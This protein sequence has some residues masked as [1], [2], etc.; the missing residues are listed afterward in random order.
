[1]MKL[2]TPRPSVA[3]RNLGSRIARSLCIVAV[4]IT[5]PLPGEERLRSG[6]EPD[7]PPFSFVN[8]QGE[9]D[10]FSVALLQAT[11]KEMGRKAD[12]KV[13]EWSVLKQAL[14][15]GGL[16][17]LPLVGRTPEREAVYDFTI[18]YL[19]LRGA[20]FVQRDQTDISGWSDLADKRVGVMKGD[21]SEEFVLRERITETPVA[22]PTFRDA[23]LAMDRGELDAVVCQKMMGVMLARELALP[24][25]Q[26][27][28]RL[29]RQYEQKFCFAVPRGQTQ[30]LGQLNEGLA[31]VMDQGIHRRLSLRWLQHGERAAALSRVILYGGD[32]NYPPYEYLDAEGRPAGFNIDLARAIARHIGVDISFT[33]GN[34]EEMRGSILRGEYD[35][36]SMLYSESRAGDLEFGLPHTQVQLGGFGRKEF[37][38]VES[39]DQLAEA[40][41]AVQ[42]GDLMH[43]LLLTE[44][45][46]ENLRLVDSLEEGLRLVAQGQVDVMLGQQH[47]SMA[48]IS[49]NRWSDILPIPALELG[50]DYAFAVKPENQILISLWNEG[51]LDVQDSGE[52]RELHKQWLGVLAPYSRW[53]SIGQWAAAAVLILLVIVAAG[54]WMLHLL[55]Q[56]VA[57]RTRDLEQ[58]NHA[59][60]RTQYAIDHFKDPVCWIGRDGRFLYVNEAAGTLLGYGHDDLVQMRITDLAVDMD[61]AQWEALWQDI[62]GKKFLKLQGEARDRNGNQIPVE[63]HASFLTLENGDCVFT[64]VQDI[65]ERKAA[66]AERNRLAAAIEQTHDT[67]VITDKTGKILYVNP[68]FTESS[69]YSREEALGENPRILKS[70]KH[71]EAFYQNMWEEL[72]SG[73]VWKGSVFN[74]RKD[75]EI[76]EEEATISPITDEKGTLLHYVAV[77]RD[78]TGQRELENQLQQ[79]QKMESIGRLAGGVA[80]DFNNLL[81]GIMGQT[82][83]CKIS[84]PGDHELQKP[85]NDILDAVE[86]S[87]VIT[88]QLLTFARKQTV[89][90]KVID[91]NQAVKDILK[92]L[93]RLIGENITLRFEP[94]P[95]IPAIRVDPGQIDQIL[96][97]LCINA[98]DAIQDHGDITLSTFREQ[99]GPEE[100]LPRAGLKVCDNGEGMNA[101]ILENLFE[102]FFTTKAPGKGTGLGLATVYGIMM[103]NRG[104]IDVTSTPG[105]G[106]CFRLWFPGIEERKKEISTPESPL[107]RG[108]A[109]VLLVDDEAFICESVKYGLEDLGYRVETATSPVTALELAK[110]PGRHFDVLITDVIMPDMNGRDLSL[111]LNK[112]FPDLNT[113]YISG[114]PEET[115]SRQGVLDPGIVLLSKPF[116][117]V[118]LARALHGILQ[119]EA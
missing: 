93:Q 70:G 33:L 15:E 35:L 94:G 112:R 45:L 97:N 64:L 108:D 51:L 39:L 48:L 76:Y 110:E 61:L 52:Y 118:Q 117:R 78:V 43:D 30:L 4:F 6:A 115:L 34:W 114:F 88:R 82:E 23:F 111:A 71:P 68:A 92:L 42:A 90:P 103:Q 109:E 16:D 22:Y 107:P 26:V 31:A 29:N 56:K 58:S 77:K 98:R 53:E 62:A 55:R 2:R 69:G 72:L 38:E 106:A 89:S 28:G 3:I 87:A 37:T 65:R 85:L 104:G 50:Y 25:I 40:R 17:I 91:L 7:Y 13:A 113:L 32:A 60:M 75:G 10:G 59:L 81:T 79:A 46:E 100:D 41:V 27:L 96:T 12:F 80:H 67:V 84:I 24:D 20:I 102:P 66:E 95:D 54:L 74:R 5:G 18:P 49:R 105:N 47:L 14:A 119:T 99:P 57:E 73:S 86:R 36:C 63:I 19:T 83:F 1:M 44:G 21:N 9:V 101:E 8:E 11:L 116:T